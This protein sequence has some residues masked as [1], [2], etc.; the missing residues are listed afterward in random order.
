MRNYVCGSGNNCMSI[1]LLRGLVCQ[2]VKNDFYRML[3]FLPLLIISLPFFYAKMKIL[4]ETRDSYESIVSTESSRKISN[5]F[6]SFTNFQ[7]FTIKLN[8]LKPFFSNSCKI[9]FLFKQHQHTPQQFSNCMK[10]LL[11]YSSRYFLPTII[12]ISTLTDMLQSL[13]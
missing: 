10:L 8:V 4:I 11:K 9:D 5:V 12:N 1:N 7:P 2:Q 6:K 3:T 13:S